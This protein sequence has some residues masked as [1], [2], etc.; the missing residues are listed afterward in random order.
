MLSIFL[1]PLLANESFHSATFWWSAL[2]KRGV[3]V[4]ASRFLVNR[5]NRLSK[6]LARFHQ[7]LFPPYSALH[8]SRWVGW[9]PLHHDLFVNYTVLNLLVQLTISIS[10]CP[11]WSA[12]W[13]SSA[14]SSVISRFACDSCLRHKNLTLIANGTH[15]L[16]WLPM[17]SCDDYQRHKQLAIVVVGVNNL[18]NSRA[19]FRPA[20]FPFL[21]SRSIL[22]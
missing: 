19:R 12:V 20:H 6:A 16:R 7:A 22:L 11:L 21:T 9:G 17:V 15:N 2:S 18:S 3:L 5:S 8:I 1:S 14:G 13:C 10:S 4:L